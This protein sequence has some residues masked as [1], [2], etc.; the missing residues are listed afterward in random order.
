[1][2]CSLDKIDL[3]IKLLCRKNGINFSMLNNDVNEMTYC[4]DN[5]QLGYIKIVVKTDD[6]SRVQEL[7]I[8]TSSKQSE[9]F[10]VKNK[11]HFFLDSRIN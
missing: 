7:S 2:G 11:R 4:F 6:E 5:Y 9:L 1:M 3:R 10:V 8:C